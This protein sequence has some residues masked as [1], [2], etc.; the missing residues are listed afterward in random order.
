[1]RESYQRLLTDPG[2]LDPQLADGEQHA[3]RRADRLLARAK[4]AMG[5]L[6]LRAA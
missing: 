6:A 4:S 3:R 5:L 1:M 2:V